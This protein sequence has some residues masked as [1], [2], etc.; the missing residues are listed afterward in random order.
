MFFGFFDDHCRKS[1]Q[2]QIK[3]LVLSGVDGQSCFCNALYVVFLVLLFKSFFILSLSEQCLTLIGGL[4]L[5]V[6][7]MKVALSFNSSIRSPYLFQ[8][9]MIFYCHGSRN[10]SVSHR[11]SCI[12]NYLAD[13]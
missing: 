13:Y 9:S 3:A 11:C 10:Q 5:C 1:V 6:A 7:D 2:Q 12:V 4:V 8:Y